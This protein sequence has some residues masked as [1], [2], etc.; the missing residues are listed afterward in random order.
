MPLANAAL[1]G[2]REMWRDLAC[3]MRSLGTASSCGDAPWLRKDSIMPSQTAP[4]E[5]ADVPAKP[6]FDYAAF[7]G[8][9]ACR[10]TLD[11]AADVVNDGVVL[12]LGACRTAL[13][14][15]I[16]TRSDLTTF[17]K[18]VTSLVPVT[19]RAFDMCTKQGDGSAAAGTLY[20]LEQVLRELDSRATA[21][22]A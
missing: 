19:M 22:I 11:A 8:T 4:D 7:A 18:S 9:D 21:S 10:Q 20:L 5:P 15:L 2:E 16:A 12:E 3:L 6:P 17:V 1:I 14:E 13:T